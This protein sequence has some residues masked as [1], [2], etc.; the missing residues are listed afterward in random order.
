MWGSFFVTSIR[1]ESQSCC[2]AL[3]LPLVGA[4]KATLYVAMCNISWLIS[5]DRSVPDRAGRVTLALLACLRGLPSLLLFPSPTLLLL[6]RVQLLIAD[7]CLWGLKTASSAEWMAVWSGRWVT[8]TSIM[9]WGRCRPRIS[10]QSDGLAC[11][12]KASADNGRRLIEKYSS[13]SWHLPW[14]ERALIQEP[15][16]QRLCWCVELFPRCLMLSCGFS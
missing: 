12:T 3:L 15:Q 5:A 13:K 1:Q 10:S 14:G 8:G 9:T 16:T 7:S 6:L 2:V 4:F 11:N